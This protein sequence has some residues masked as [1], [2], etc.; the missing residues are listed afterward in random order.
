MSFRPLVVKLALVTVGS[1]LI[2]W[3]PL[4]TVGAYS[5]HTR[6]LDQVDDRAA[7]VAAAAQRRTEAALDGV[8]DRLRLL[9]RSEAVVAAYREFEEAVYAL[10]EDLDKSGARLRRAYLG[11]QPLGRATLYAAIHDKEDAALTGLARTTGADNL[12]V[13]SPARFFV[14]YAVDKRE[15]FAAPLGDPADDP[16]A[17]AVREIFATDGFG[18]GF[19]GFPV[20]ADSSGWIAAPIRDG[21]RLLGALAAKVPAALLG[22]PLADVAAIS[23]DVWVGIFTAEGVLIA[24]QGAVADRLP[25]RIGT[26]FS[27]LTAESGIV[28]LADPAGSWRVAAH[29]VDLAGWPAVVVAAAPAPRSGSL[30]ATLSLTFVLAVGGAIA[31]GVA[32]GGRFVR[33]LEA[34]TH[35]LA[36]LAQTGALPDDAAAA[37]PHGLGSLDELAGDLQRKLEENR[38][39]ATQEKNGLLAYIDQLET[40]ARKQAA[41]FPAAESEGEP[42]VI[43]KVARQSE[44]ERSFAEKGWPRLRDRLHQA[45]R[46]VESGDADALAETKNGLREVIAELGRGFAGLAGPP[47]LSPA[48]FGQINLADL[49]LSRAQAFSERAAAKNLD[50]TFERTEVDPLVRGDETAL[51]AIVDALVDNAVRYTPNGGRIDL[52]VEDDAENGTVRLEIADDGLGLAKGEEKGVF[53]RFRQG[54]AAAAVGYHGLGLGLSDVQA[55]SIAHG[56]RIRT[57]ASAAEGAQFTLEFP[58][59]VAPQQSSL[60]GV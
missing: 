19:T 37:P 58:S 41:A 22:D 31:L 27:R 15:R 2:G 29:G 4:A 8:A 39:E 28:D 32:V 20:G 53:E 9:G 33:R 21:N 40:L 13:V 7:G 55:L 34:V 50:V 30:I 43:K 36:T 25:Q 45:A 49:V 11:D 42:T 5:E 47:P 44:E 57:G 56:A 10:D 1:A 26:I 24:Q 14:L 23:P 60:P 46:A 18:S 35:R 38:A 17:A 12:L 48:R 16:A 3:A 54:T 51:T 52:R 6:R 59:A